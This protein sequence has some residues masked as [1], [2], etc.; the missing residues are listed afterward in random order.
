MRVAETSLEANRTR[1]STVIVDWLWEYLIQC[2]ENG[3]TADEALE[4]FSHTELS[5]RPGL[6]NPYSSITAR[7]RG[8]KFNKFIHNPDGL[9]RLT[10]SNKKALVW[11]ARSGVDFSTYK[12][13]P[14]KNREVEGRILESARDWAENHEDESLLEVLLDT[15]W[16]AYG[17]GER[18]KNHLVGSE[19][20][21]D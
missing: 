21:F 17:K 16:E 8:L 5:K 12:E 1:K 10:R 4:A 20:L 14:V 2:G 9:K 7:M 18:P 13:P 19:G 11:V 3:S 15:V 6:D